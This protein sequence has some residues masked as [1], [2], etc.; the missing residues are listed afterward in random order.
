MVSVVWTLMVGET[1]RGAMY[2]TSTMRYLLLHVSQ[3][4]KKKKKKIYCF[5]KNTIYTT[6]FSYHDKMLTSNSLKEEE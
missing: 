3:K 6:N 5:I 4:K 2:K 1:V